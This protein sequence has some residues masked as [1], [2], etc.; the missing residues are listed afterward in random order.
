[1]NVNNNVRVKLTAA[2]EKVLEDYHTRLS[3][4][5]PMPAAGGYREFPLWEWAQIFG[6]AMHMGM[7]GTLFEENNIL[8]DIGDAVLSKK[9]AAFD[10][11]ASGEATGSSVMY[12]EWNSLAG[13]SMEVIGAKLPAMAAKEAMR[14]VQ[15]A[16]KKESLWV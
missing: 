13:L 5:A 3:S 4:K 2:G 6:Q 14:V 16:N 9:A 15:M 1:M 12:D 10:M 8:V 11:V 7:V